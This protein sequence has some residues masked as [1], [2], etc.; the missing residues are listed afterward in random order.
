MRGRTVTA[1]AAVLLALLILALLRRHAAAPSRFVR[2]LVSGL[3]SF[4]VFSAF[5]VPLG[6]SD[7]EV[8]RQPWVT[9]GIV[10]ACLL[11]FQLQLLLQPGPGWRHDLQGATMNSIAAAMYE[12]AGAGAVYA[13]TLTRT[14]SAH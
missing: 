7:R 1:T 2:A 14:R 4:A 10:L 12:N 9:Y 6:P 3:G 11:V 13:L 8:R 5:V